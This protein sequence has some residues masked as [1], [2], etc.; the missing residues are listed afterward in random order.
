MSDKTKEEVVVSHFIRATHDDDRNKVYTFPP[1]GLFKAMDE[2]ADQEKRKEAIGFAEWLDDN[3]WHKQEGWFLLG[4][5]AEN[6]FGE[7]MGSIKTLDNLYDLYL[8]SL[9]KT[10]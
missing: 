9:P 7:T 1:G 5:C 2:W 10:V 3:A 6:R 8:Q 4:D